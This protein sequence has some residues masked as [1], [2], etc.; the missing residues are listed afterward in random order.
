MDI[1][2]SDEGYELRWNDNQIERIELVSS[3]SIAEAKEMLN[4]RD[5][6]F[7]VTTNNSRGIINFLEHFQTVNDVPIAKS[8]GRI[9]FIKGEIIHP[10]LEQDITIKPRSS[11]EKQLHQAFKEKGV[12]QDWKESILDVIKPFP[13]VMFMTLASFASVL[14]QE[15]EVPSF[16][17]DL[18]GNTSQGKSMTL[19]VA[20]SVWGVPSLHGYMQTFNGTLISFERKSDFL[21]SYPFIV[22][23]SKSGDSRIYEDMIYTFTTGRGKGRGALQGSCKEGTWSQIMLTSGEARLA[24]Y[25]PNA[26]GVEGRI[27]HIE[28]EPFQGAENNF[29]TLLHNKNLGIAYGVAGKEFVRR[30]NN[31]TLEEKDKHKKQY[32]VLR[33][34]YMK[35]A[36]NNHVLRRLSTYY[37][38]IHH[39][40]ELLNEWF[41]FDIVPDFCLDLFAD[42]NENNKGTNKPFEIL[43]NLLD[44]LSS[45]THTVDMDPSRVPT[46]INAFVKDDILYL[47]PN[48]LKEKL[49]SDIKTIRREWL[50]QG[51]TLLGNS[52]D[53]TSVNHRGNTTRAVAINPNTLISMGISFKEK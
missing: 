13:K 42:D 11:G 31:L 21:N 9:G 43:S 23:D 28:D 30:L 27:V 25:A 36:G 12:L 15:Y 18:S 35:L 53:L 34:S 50:K 7:P 2:T 46:I 22:D 24:S 44:E 17:V 16:I 4:L 37:A 49:G 14:L 10:L 48:Y 5:I 32:M 40:A 33:D 41:A 38:I 47:M 19:R 6:G 52:K 45:L 26:G 39:A 1:E 8:V 29:L 20:S 51:L 3:R